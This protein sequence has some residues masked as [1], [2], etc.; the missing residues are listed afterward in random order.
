V[1]EQAPRAT[2]GQVLRVPEF[3]AL[4][5]SRTLS[6][7]AITLRMLAVSVLVL[8]TTG[9][10]LMAGLA[11][12][13]G[14]LPQVLGGMTLIALADRVRPRRALVLGSLLEAGTALVIA[15]TDLP[16]WALLLVLAGVATVTPVFN[17]AASGLLPS[18]L[19]GDRYVLGRSLMVLTSSGAQVAGL[20]LGGAVLAV[21]APREVL[22]VVAG[23]HLVAALLSRLL[24][25][26]RPPRVTDRTRGTVG[27]TWRGNRELLADRQVRGQV[28]A[29]VLPPS[30]VTGAE[31]LVVAY[32]AQLEG[33]PS[34]TG[35][36]LAC[37]P[38]GMGLGSFAIG[39]L[40][41]PPARERLVLPL[42]VVVAV[43][44][45]L[46]ALRPPLPVAG[47]LLLASSAALAYEL[48][49]QQR[50]L[51]VTP[52][53]RRGQAFG[54]L[55]TLLMFGQGLAPVAAGALASL[56]SPSVAVALTGGAVAVC[57]LAL[58]PHLL[59]RPP[60]PAGTVSRAAAEPAGR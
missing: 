37:A 51:D 32:V 34:A 19:A 18:L 29:Q 42:L 43:P 38:V 30:L 20:G 27:A 5:A 13:I 22:F 46:F 4:F 54:L 58:R 21:L 48:G 45:V 3:R 59:P 7:A 16:A 40:C 10:P 14:F 39:R 33:P 56:W 31:G 26:D 6:I 50:F 25:T 36:L 28:L 53:A 35:L 44:L 15:T 9:S 60:G 41:A 52:E 55:S 12:G 1:S 47:G 17:A 57:A 8:S 49:L 24:L 23:L 2:Y 11:F